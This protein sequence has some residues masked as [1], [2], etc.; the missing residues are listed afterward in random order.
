MQRSDAIL[1][2]SSRG[3]PQFLVRALE[4][5][6]FNLHNFESNDP[7]FATVEF[8][9]KKVVP[10]ILLSSPLQYTPDPLTPTDEGTRF[11]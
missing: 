8:V 4:R 1:E 6:H 5:N 10:D 7:A 11:F 3:E 9:L 2:G